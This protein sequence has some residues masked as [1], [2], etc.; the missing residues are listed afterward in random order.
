MK[1]KSRSSKSKRGTSAME[2]SKQR[3]VSNKSSKA[4]HSSR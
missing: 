1:S 3:D 2:E 4:S